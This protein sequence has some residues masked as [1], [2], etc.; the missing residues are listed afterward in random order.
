MHSRLE[1]GGNSLL[2]RGGMFETLYSHLEMF[3]TAKIS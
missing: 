1:N 2:D 3:Y